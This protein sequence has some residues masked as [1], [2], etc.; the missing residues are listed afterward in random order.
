MAN[1]NLFIL[2][3]IQIFLLLIKKQDNNTGQA[4]AQ[5]IINKFI[6]GK[7]VLDSTTEHYVSP[8]LNVSNNFATIDYDALISTKIEYT[9][10]H[11]FRSLTVHG[12]NALH[13]ICELERNQLLTL[14]AMSVQNP[15]LAAFLLAGI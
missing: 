11:V 1:L 14:L 5:S 4:N 2:H 3:K 13:T 12:L 6:S 7:T 10:N 15:Q 9:I 8:A